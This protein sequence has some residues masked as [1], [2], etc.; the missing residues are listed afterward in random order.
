[1][2]KRKPTAR[3]VVLKAK[4]LRHAR[5]S[6]GLTQLALGQSLGK[7]HYMTVWRAEAG[8]AIDVAEAQAIANALEV[9]LR[10]LIART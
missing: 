1:M 10:F 6:K 2:K 9:P 7:H 8:R 5:K 4:M 3:G